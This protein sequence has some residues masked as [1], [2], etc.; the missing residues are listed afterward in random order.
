MHNVLRL[1]LYTILYKIYLTLHS[2][3]NIIQLQV[4]N[5]PADPFGLDLRVLATFHP[6][7]GG[8]DGF[9]DPALQF[10]CALCYFILHYER[11][12]IFCRVEHS[13]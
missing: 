10:P 8:I 9:S 2:L 6:L 1:T 13:W 12:I 5:V 7:E 4:D 3:I 11:S